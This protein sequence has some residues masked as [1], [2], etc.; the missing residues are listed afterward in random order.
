MS[1][2][3]T[4]V[5]LTAAAAT[6]GLAALGG[7]PTAGASPAA[8][9]TSRVPAAHGPEL[10]TS[11]RLADR[12][13]LVLGDRFFEVGAEDGTYPAQGW[14][15]TGEMG[16]FWSQPIKLLDGMWFAVNGSWLTADTYTS[17]HGYARM[18]LGTVD[19]VHVQRVDVAPDGLRAG[20][21]GLTFTAPTPRKVKLDLDAHS[22]LLSAYPWG[23]TAPGQADFNLP[24]TGSFSGRSLVF[25]EQ[26][27]PPVA[28][29]AP[30]DWAAVVGA[31]FA[32]T[33]HQLG[34]AFR[35]PQ[36]DV[37][38]P[39]AGNDNAKCDDSIYGKG[40][41]GRL[42]YD[43]QLPRGGRTVWF[44][45]GGSDHGLKAAQ[46]AQQRA[47][48]RPEALLAAK[49][50]AR[51]KVSAM[52]SVDLPGDRLLQQS[53][54]WSKQNL[55]DSVQQA[56]DLHL[57]VTHEGKQYPA[58]AGTLARAR[59][60]GAGWPDYP[61]IFGTDGEYSAF[62]AVASGQFAAI[63]DHLRTLRDVNDIVNDHSGK[64]VHEVV[65]DGSVYFGANSDS[66]NT[67][68]TVK[69]PSAVALV[70]R[71][72]GDNR[73]RDQMYDFAV[74]NMRYVYANLDADGDGWPEG[75]GNVERTGMGP[76]KLDNG[77][78]AIRG[79]MDLADMASSKG[80]TAT[81]DWAEAKAATLRQAFEQTWWNG[82]DTKSY[83]DSLDDPGN[84]QV[85]QR[86]W[87]G[88]TPVEAELPAR[89]ST[90]AGPAADAEHAATTV[91][92]HELPCYTGQYGLF[93]TGT[94][95]TTDPKGNPGPTC[96]SAVSSAPSDRE[97]FTLG[98]SIAA[99]AEAAIGRTGADQLQRYQDMLATVQVD[100]NV[101]ETPGAMPE[102]APSPD[103]VANIDRSWTGRSMALQAWGTYGVLWPVVHFELGV[104]PD[105]GNG[106]LSV[107]PQ[108]PEGQHRVAGRDIRL[109][110]GSVDVEAQ[111]T[112]DSLTTTV[113]N[114]S[115]ARLTV[116][117][118]LPSGAT[119]HSATLDGQPVALHVVHTARGDVVTAPVPEGTS[120]A[121]M[122]V[123]YT[124]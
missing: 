112:S 41:G 72:T 14:H 45:V 96:D 101:F 26:G 44:A 25:R 84:V 110:R 90:P 8:Y 78:Y 123:R 20:L 64:V 89:A 36:G 54:E 103:F 34:E 122:V 97:V 109:G 94:G 48:A 121:T 60:I 29:A 40:T 79:L 99:V 17:G 13:S 11:T 74:R 117:A 75:A 124:S 31:R 2:R 115:G 77:V 28:N 120:A 43:L 76:E 95:A 111:R 16:G 87:T 57:R 65:P 63:E 24:D 102:I 30:H 113:H 86:Y 49:V 6:A 119:A 81:R 19:G 10:S 35:G 1:R 33:S 104:A 105:L 47:L 50:A 82:S 91:A 27:T 51:A 100:P 7:A 23:W 15:I 70:W 52:T 37:R 5:A 42:S 55:A 32:P 69:F 88:L 62:S 93:H 4:L 3:R 53:V 39:V 58:P 12:R 71:W 116:G 67:D 85:F 83:A 18:D 61:W 98:T 107:V 9:G 92:Q 108:V 59:W 66:G 22:E 118:V 46:R 114:R 80:D 106:T 68:E 21:V 38:C 73:F 56:D